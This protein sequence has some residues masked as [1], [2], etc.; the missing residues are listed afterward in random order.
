MYPPKL[1]VRPVSVFLHPENCSS[2]PGSPIPCILQIIRLDYLYCFVHTANYPP[3]PVSAVSWI[4]QT[5]PSGP[6]SAVLASGNHLSGPVSAL[7]AS[8]KLSVRTCLCCSFFLQIIQQ[9]LFPL[10]PA[11]CKISHQDLFPLLLHSSNYPSRSVFLYLLHPA[12]YLF[13]TCL[14]C[15]CVLQTIH[16]M[17]SLPANYQPGPVSAAPCILGNY[18]SGPVS[19]APSSCKLFVRS[20]LR[21]S[22][23]LKIICQD[24][25]PLFLHPFRL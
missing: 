22:C 8:C 1:S 11:S 2:G 6:V 5:Y 13:K 16:Q 25:P 19:T 24:L 15:C 20:N 7:P 10:F 17:L 12:N 9:E 18:S 21:C 14:L 4:L 3:G 23:I